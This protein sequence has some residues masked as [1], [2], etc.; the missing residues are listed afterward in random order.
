MRALLSR[1][2]S[3][4]SFILGLLSFL[5]SAATIIGIVQHFTAISLSGF[6]L[7]AYEQYSAIRDKIFLPIQFLLFG[8]WSDIHIPALIQDGVALYLFFGVA[9]EETV[10]W[11]DAFVPMIVRRISGIEVRF[12]EAE[13]AGAIRAR[14]A[15]LYRMV[16]WPAGVWRWVR[17]TGTWKGQESWSARATDESMSLVLKARWAHEVAFLIAFPFAILMTAACVCGFYYWSYLESLP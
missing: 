15:S 5:G 13:P 17:F 16:T 1:I 12:G 11:S 10:A 3:S 14:L 9:Y 6:P 4:F 8:W 7:H 2:F